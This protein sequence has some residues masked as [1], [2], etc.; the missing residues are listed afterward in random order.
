MLSTSLQLLGTSYNPMPSGCDARWASA[1]VAK[2]HEIQ[3]NPATG[4]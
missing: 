2:R 3:V 1:F 4:T